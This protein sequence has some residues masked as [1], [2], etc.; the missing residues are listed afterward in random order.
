MV[1]A[2]SVEPL[3]KARRDG[4]ESES[5]HRA[6]RLG[7]VINDSEETTHAHIDL[8]PSPGDKDRAGKPGRMGAYKTLALR[9]RSQRYLLCSVE[10]STAVPM[11]LSSLKGSSF[12]RYS[13]VA[14]RPMGAPRILVQYIIDTCNLVVVGSVPSQ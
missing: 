3:I 13:N 5:S 1:G 12:T 7:V 9:A 14:L 8:E 4:S 10:Q 6:T 2:M 11:A